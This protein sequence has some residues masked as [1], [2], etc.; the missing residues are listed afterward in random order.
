VHLSDKY[1]MAQKLGQLQPF[2]AVSPQKCIGQLASSGQPNT[3]LALACAA[4]GEAL[5]GTR[6]K[7]AARGFTNR[8]VGLQRGPAVVV[9]RRHAGLAAA[10]PRLAGVAAAVAV[11]ERDLRRRIAPSRGQ[12][13]IPPRQPVLARLG[14]QEREVPGRLR[15][16]QAGRRR[17]RRLAARARRARRPP[18]AA[19]LGFGRIVSLQKQRHPIGLC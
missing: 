10:V 17:R 9:R 12:P 3:F 14:R 11:A 5:Q 18:A 1:T 15:R 4:G 2:M 19:D 8:L 13:E 6:T 16:R 7:R